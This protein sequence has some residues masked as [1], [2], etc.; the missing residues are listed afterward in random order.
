MAERKNFI[1][2]TEQE[3]RLV[4]SWRNDSRIKKWMHTKEDISWEAHLRFI[5]SLKSTRHKDYF[6]VLDKEEY[7]GVIDLNHEFL[8]IYANPHKQRVGDVL[9]Q[10][11]I[12]FAFTCKGLP[13]LKAEVYKENTKAIK[14]YERFGFQ[15]IHNDGTMLTM[16]RT[17][18]TRAF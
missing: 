3:A 16:E 13:R 6:L 7:L 5:E 12:E 9:L 10:E 2:L 11:I 17:N 18:E 15:T 1:D 8:G 14:L 4:L